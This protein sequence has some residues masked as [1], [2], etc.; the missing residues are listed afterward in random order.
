MILLKIGYNTLEITMRKQ[1]IFNVQKICE[2]T[3]ASGKTLLIFS[4]QQRSNQNKLG[5]CENRTQQ[6][7]RR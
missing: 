2:A 7:K 3:K 4:K 5:F 6:L 1:A